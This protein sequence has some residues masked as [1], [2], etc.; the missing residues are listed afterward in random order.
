MSHSVTGE[1]RASLWLWQEWLHG[2]RRDSTAAVSDPDRW[3][4][5]P[6]T[7]PALA[8]GLQGFCQRYRGCFRTATWDASPYAEPYVGA[9]LRMERR[10]TFTN[11]G[12]QVGMPGQNVQHFVTN[13][14][15][16]A[17]GVLRQV[18]QEIAARSEPQ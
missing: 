9:L 10:R 8:G 12:R 1:P 15:R 11:I 17:A 4:I 3:G 7:I 13:S 2:T 16:S 14:P 18:R 5:S 6:A